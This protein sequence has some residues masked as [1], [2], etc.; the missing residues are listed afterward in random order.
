LKD[1]YLTLNHL[2]SNKLQGAESCI[3]LFGSKAKGT[4]FAAAGTGF[5]VAGEAEINV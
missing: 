3:I 2:G 4:K 1:L 5:S